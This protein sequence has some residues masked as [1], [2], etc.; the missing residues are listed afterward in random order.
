MLFFGTT[1]VKAEVDSIEMHR[2]YN[3]YSGEHFY[4]GDINEKNHLA[5]IGWNYE[6]IGW[7]SDE[8]QGVPSYRQ[9][10]PYE[11][12]G[13]HNYTTDK[14]ENDFLV[15]IGW[16]SEFV[17]VQIGTIPVE[18]PA[19]YGTR[20]VVDQTAYDELVLIGYSCSCRA[21]K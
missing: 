10:N 20:Y 17:Q 19:E 14:E 5:S 2:L 1:P 11:K 9:Y 21:K 8:D 3:P 18:H 12:T 4:T 6:G 15:S 13:T 7:Y 16:K